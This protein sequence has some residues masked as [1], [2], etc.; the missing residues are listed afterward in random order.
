MLCIFRTPKDE[1]T[2]REYAKSKSE[3]TDRRMPDYNAYLVKHIMYA[4]RFNP[5][6]EE[7]AKNMLIEYYTK[8]VK[9]AGSPRILETLFRLARTRARLKLKDIVDMEDAKDTMEFYNVS[10][11]QHEQA[12]SIPLNPIDATYNECVAILEKYSFSISFEE[13]IKT[14]CA[15]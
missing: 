6:L 10:L 3:T 1:K 15:R 5:I 2:I 7:E 4:K 11:E 13:L 12:I 14:A 9:S 8:I